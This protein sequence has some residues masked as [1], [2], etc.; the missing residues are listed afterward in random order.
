MRNEP[1]PR[2]FASPQEGQRALGG[3]FT[4]WVRL[5]DDPDHWVSPKDVSGLPRH[6]LTP[7][8]VAALSDRIVE[9]V[10]LQRPRGRSLSP[11]RGQTLQAPNAHTALSWT[12]YGGRK[13]R[14]K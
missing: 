14:R 9:K 12:D 11:H 6:Q 10:V 1:R 13:R 4:T 5:R 8:H 7:Y 2:R 3:K